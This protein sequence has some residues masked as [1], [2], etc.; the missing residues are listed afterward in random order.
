MAGLRCIGPHSALAWKIRN[1][2]NPTIAA[3]TE[4][5]RTLILAM[6]RTSGEGKA[7]AAIK[8][9]IVKPIPARVATPRI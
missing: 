5:Q 1:K 6:S 9:D 2:K 8:S 3:T 7:S 4:A